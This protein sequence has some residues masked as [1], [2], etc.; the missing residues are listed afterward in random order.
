MTPNAPVTGRPPAEGGESDELGGF[1]W[2][3][4][5]AHICL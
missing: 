5:L 4:N 3:L 2:C 1:N